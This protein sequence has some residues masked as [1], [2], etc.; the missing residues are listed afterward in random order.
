M[1]CT[2]K[3]NEFSSKTICFASYDFFLLCSGAR[4]RYIIT[5]DRVSLVI[6]KKFGA[7]RSKMFTKKIKYKYVH[8]IVKPIYSCFDS[9]WTLLPTIWFFFLHIH[10]MMSKN[11]CIISMTQTLFEHVQNPCIK[12]NTIEYTFVAML[13]IFIPQRKCVE[14]VINFISTVFNYF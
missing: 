14:K 10:K 13:S 9:S 5:S 3:R 8:I 4:I 11:T 1:V 6:R 12:I 2:N 7:L